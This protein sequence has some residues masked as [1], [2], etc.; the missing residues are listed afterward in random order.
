MSAPKNQQLTVP[1]R[2]ADLTFPYA[3]YWFDE[4]VYATYYL[5]ITKEINQPVITYQHSL[6]RIIDPFDTGVFSR[7]VAEAYKTWLLEK[8][9]FEKESDSVSSN[10]ED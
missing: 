10:S 4:M 7:A 2:Q 5:D 8:S 6:R 1:T 3:Q 9:F